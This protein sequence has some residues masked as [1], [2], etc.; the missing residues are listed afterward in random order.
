[1]VRHTLREKKQKLRKNYK[2]NQKINKN[3][4]CTEAALNV[5]WWYTMKCR[6]VLQLVHTVVFTLVRP[7]GKA[8]CLHDN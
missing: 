6:F 1:M 2:K 4:L 7:T 5:F 3:C 8:S